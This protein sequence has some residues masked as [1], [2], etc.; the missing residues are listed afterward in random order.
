[1]RRLLL[2]GV[3]ALVVIPPASADINVWLDR[4][5]AQPGDVVRATSAGCCYLSLYLVPERLV[6]NPW[7][8]SANAICAPFSVGPPHR[9]GWTWL[10]R[11]FPNR[12]SLWFRVPKVRPGPYRAVVY[13]APCYRGPRGSLIAGDRLVVR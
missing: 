13:C 5:S 7:H 12:R 4:S 1:M 11:F 6:P 2:I 9:H 8:C 3:A 10:G